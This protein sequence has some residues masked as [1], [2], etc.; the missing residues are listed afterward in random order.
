MKALLVIVHQAAEMYAL[1]P[2]WRICRL[3]RGLPLPFGES[4]RRIATHWWDQRKDRGIFECVVY[5]AWRATGRHPAAPNIDDLML[6]QDV[7][8]PS[9]LGSFI[10]MPWRLLMPACR[11]SRVSRLG[12]AS[13]GKAI[14]LTQS[15]AEWIRNC[16]VLPRLVCPAWCSTGQQHQS[17]QAS[18]A[19]SRPLSTAQR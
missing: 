16:I 4:K 6:R 10:C 19:P 3:I 17:A 11:F 14:P 7:S 12:N 2:A 18:G 8:R 9:P 1:C 15:M 5:R 13:Q